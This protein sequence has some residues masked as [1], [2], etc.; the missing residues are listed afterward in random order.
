[1]RSKAVYT[2]VKL[3]GSKN[4]FS[5]LKIYLLKKKKFWS[6]KT[7]SQKRILKLEYEVLCFLKCIPKRLQFRLT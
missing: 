1:M 7:K 4:A 2:T 6:D 3:L 5:T